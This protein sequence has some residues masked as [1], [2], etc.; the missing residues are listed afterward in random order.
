MKTRPSFGPSNLLYLLDVEPISTMRVVCYA[1]TLDNEKKASLLNYLIQSCNKKW[2]CAICYAFLLSYL[3]YLLLSC[4][5]QLRK[6]SGVVKSKPKVSCFLLTFTNTSSRVRCHS[7]ACS[8]FSCF[9]FFL[10][11]R[12]FFFYF[13]PDQHSFCRS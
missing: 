11:F 3:L 13:L 9:F 7:I 8:S 1:A 12:I 4:A 2:V 5:P 6:S 10:G